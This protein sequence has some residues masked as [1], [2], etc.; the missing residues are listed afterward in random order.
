MS[1]TSISFVRRS[2]AAIGAFI[3][4]NQTA[5]GL[6]EE[7]LALGYIQ[8]DPATGEYVRDAEGHLV[9][10]LTADDVA[11]DGID[12]NEFLEAMAGSLTTLDSIPTALVR[13]MYRVRSTQTVTIVPPVI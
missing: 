10:T 4:D 7:A 11:A 9:S 5:Q 6:K 2:R 1:E 12:L 13:L 3:K 8:V